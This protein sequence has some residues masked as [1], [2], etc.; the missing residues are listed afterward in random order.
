MMDRLRRYVPLVP[1]YSLVVAAGLVLGLFAARVTYE[2]WPARALPLA[3][4]PAGLALALGIAALV[5]GLYHRLGSRAG[6]R[7]FSP[8]IVL[9][10][11]ENFCLSLKAR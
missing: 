2:L 1:T 7:A 4:W 8:W 3:S 6:L 5:A 10:L 9:P 11:R